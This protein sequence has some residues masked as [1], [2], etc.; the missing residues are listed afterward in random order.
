[1]SIE[2]LI[3]AI[4]NTPADDSKLEVL[5]KSCL[6]EKVF[7]STI[8]NDNIKK[9]IT[10]L[11]DSKKTAF[12]NKLLI[13]EKI[14]EKKV[15]VAKEFDASDYVNNTLRTKEVFDILIELYND[16]MA[17]E[18]ELL[19][20]SKNADIVE[21]GDVSRTNS[22]ISNIKNDLNK[23]TEQIK[24]Q[25]KEIKEQTKQFDSKVF[26]VLLNTVTILGIFVAISF[27]GFGAFNIFNNIDVTTWMQNA[28]SFIKNTFILMLTSFLAYNLLLLLVYFIYKLSRP[29][30]YNNSKK[31]DE[32][33]LNELQANNRFF[34]YVNFEPF[35]WIDGILLAI[36][37]TLFFVSIF[38]F[39]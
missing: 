20:K 3:K 9:A 30:I 14:C 13:L 34:T 11:E 2:E 17:E 37:L 5:F 39:K 19:A 1:M 8:D 26:Q 28:E 35:L 27:T 12:G 18:A 31:T 7:E 22:S 25:E 29:I 6:K 10:Q 16:A 24:K 4:N 23:I 21:L 15:D 38:C 36:V 32:S 33:A